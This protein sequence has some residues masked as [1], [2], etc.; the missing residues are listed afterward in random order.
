MDRFVGEQLPRL[1]E[2][3][4]DAALD[5]SRWQA[6]L[7]ALTPCFGGATG[8]MYGFDGVRGAMDFTYNFGSDPAFIQSYD[9]YY[10]RINPYPN[11]ALSMPP[12][13][14]A[15]AADAL[16]TE[17]LCRTE[18][19]N[20]WMRPQEIPAEYFGMLVHKHG[21]RGVVMGL[22]PQAAL[23]NRN[24]HIYLRQLRLLM[25]HMARA[26]ELNRIAAVGRQTV[27]VLGAALEALAAGAFLIDR[28]GRIVLANQRGE[29]L[30]RSQCALSVSPCGAVRAA[31]PRCDSTL[32]AA[33]VIAATQRRTSPPLRLVCP[34]SG[35]QFIAWV[36]P[37]HA[38]QATQTNGG[39]VLVDAFEQTATALLL[40]APADRS[41]ATRAEAIAAVFQLSAAEAKLVC[42][43]CAGLTLAEYA[44][45]VE[46]SRNTVRNQLAGV[47][48]KT[49]TSRQSELVSRVVA[50]LGRAP[51]GLMES[52]PQNSA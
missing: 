29:A 49:R 21:S 27:R 1:L 44:G 11:L 28:A 37:T 47:F 40:V 34:N 39:G 4:Y 42:A 46:L 52:D 45:Q 7:D 17:T 50:T 14:V 18:F 15:M 26:A 48:A 16:D 9:R 8:I 30:M 51:G 2:L 19:F 3:L 35:R 23:L 38:S 32:Q 25:P 43:L 13:K 12:G 5:H 33:L 20:D 6:F 36:V 22:A 24:Q 41:A 10:G 31:G